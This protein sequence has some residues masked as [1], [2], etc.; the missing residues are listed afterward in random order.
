MK[1]LLYLPF[2]LL[3]LSTSCKKEEHNPVKTIHKNQLSLK[4]NGKLQALT[5]STSWLTPAETFLVIEAG[6]PELNSGYYRIFIQ[7]VIPQG[8]Y[9]QLG[10]NS[11]YVITFE[12]KKNYQTWH[13]SHDGTVQILSNDPVAKRIEFKFDIDLEN[14][15][16][17]SDIIELREGHIIANY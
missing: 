8:I 9:Y 7:P 4:R 11:P 5:V 15:N 6:S 12:F 2:L 3:A 1:K 16:I 13:T 14:V 10:T 17:P